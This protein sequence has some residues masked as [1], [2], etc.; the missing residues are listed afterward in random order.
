MYPLWTD[1][2]VIARHHNSVYSTAASLTLGLCTTGG[3]VDA[4][5]AAGM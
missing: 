4:L 3:L 2:Y 1:V 5:D